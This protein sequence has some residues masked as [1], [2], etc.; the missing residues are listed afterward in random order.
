MV[1]NKYCTVHENTVLVWFGSRLRA[2]GRRYD[3]A[4]RTVPPVPRHSIITVNKS[5]NTTFVHVVYTFMMS[6]MSLKAKNKKRKTAATE[7]INNAAAIAA[8]G[9]LGLSSLPAARIRTGHSNSHKRGTGRN[10]TIIREN[11]MTR[12]LVDVAK[13]RTHQ[14][15]LGNKIEAI[16]KKNPRTRLY[17]C[18][19]CRLGPYTYRGLASHK[20]RC[21][22]TDRAVA[23]ASAK[24][25]AAVGAE[26][27]ERNNAIRT[28]PPSTQAKKRPKTSSASAPGF[29]ASVPGFNASATSDSNGAATAADIDMELDDGDDDYAEAD[30]PSILFDDMFKAAAIKVGEKIDK[31]YK[32]RTSKN[33]TSVPEAYAHNP[34]MRSRHWVN[35]MTQVSGFVGPAFI[36]VWAPDLWWN[37]D[38]E[39]VFKKAFFPR[40][41][42]S[43][44]TPYIFSCISQGPPAGDLIKLIFFLAISL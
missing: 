1:H 26:M 34:M 5:I 18:Q 9:K 30:E 25:P 33:P 4:T 28:D 12:G 17:R 35:D 44:R 20:P 37:R 11:C 42:V 38:W 41:T 29:N 3:D 7:V 14:L 16:L 15:F 27:V 13:C 21:T 19:R 24:V 43:F 36:F 10:K 31:A 6:S 22:A 2:G 8:W 32:S 40:S 23:K 39:L